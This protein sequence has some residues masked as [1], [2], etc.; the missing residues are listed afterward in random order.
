M[1]NHICINEYLC[2]HPRDTFQSHVTVSA[3][4]NPQRQTNELADRWMDGWNGRR[5]APEINIS[6]F[7]DLRLS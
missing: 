2:E 7:E 4:R 6:I 5:K 1:L 3:L